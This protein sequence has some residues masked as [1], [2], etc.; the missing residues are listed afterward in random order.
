MSS[1]RGAIRRRLIGEMSRFIKS[2]SKV[3]VLTKRVMIGSP[4]R[5]DLWFGPKT[6]LIPSVSIAERFASKTAA[7][8]AEAKSGGEQ[9]AFRYP[10]FWSA[11]FIGRKPT[12]IL[13]GLLRRHQQLLAEK[14]SNQRSR[15]LRLVV[16]LSVYFPAAADF[17]SKCRI[18]VFL[19]CVMDEWYATTRFLPSAL[20]L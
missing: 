16:A 11:I 4:S 5:I 13:M 6:I 10:L 20:A 3:V 9:C 14:N 17:G 19:I 2:Y 12:G 7:Q 18:L 8:L 1:E 15:A